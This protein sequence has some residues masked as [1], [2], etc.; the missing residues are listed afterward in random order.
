MCV[1]RISDLMT[2][3][4]TEKDTWVV[5]KGEAKRYPDPSSGNGLAMQNST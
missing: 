2:F 5:L 1:G 4:T 3:L